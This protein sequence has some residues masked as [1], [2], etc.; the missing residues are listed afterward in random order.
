MVAQY[1]DESNLICR[2][3]R[4][5]AQARGAR[6]ALPA[7]RTRPFRDHR[8]VAAH[9]VHR[10]DA[11]RRREADIAALLLARAAST[12][13]RCRPRSR[14][15][16]WPTSSGATRTR[17]AS[18]SPS[19]STMGI[20]GFTINMPAN[21]HIEGRVELLGRTLAPLVV[22]SSSA[23]AGIARTSD[24]VFG[25]VLLAALGALELAARRL[26]E[27]SGRHEHHV[28]R[29]EAAHLERAVVDPFADLVEATRRVAHAN[30]GHDHHALLALVALHAE[31]DHVAGTHAVERPDGALDVLGEHVA[32]ADDDHVL[33]PPAQ[34]EFTVEQVG[35]VAGAQPSVAEQRGGGVGPLV[36]AGRDR[37]AAEEQ[38]AD[39]ALGHLLVGVGVDHL[40]L[41]AG[42]RACRAA[43]VPGRRRRDRRRRAPRPV[44]R[45]AAS[46]APRRSTTSVRRP[47]PRGGNVPAI[48]TS[49]MPNAGNTPPG[50]NPNRDASATNA[51]TACGV[52]RF[53]ARQGQRQLRQVEVAA[54]A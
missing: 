16:G 43:A 40:H 32:S 15:R 41:Q 13:P 30:L 1:A 35:E 6:R 8:V 47:R 23:A 31:G 21:G 5:A 33:D 17:S 12:S 24:E 19:S 22:L 50:W 7:A 25:E 20:D 38:F 49:A 39:V 26:R 29:R 3:A 37:R 2:P 45:H 54:S 46:R 9:G 4:S 51:S 10:P 42:H 48:A 34:H 36:V 14:R 44:W 11:R 27:R 52:D 53:G 18:S 28:A